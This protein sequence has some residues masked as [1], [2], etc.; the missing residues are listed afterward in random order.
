MRFLFCFCLNFW[1]AFLSLAQSQPS[2]DVVAP[3]QKDKN[4]PSFTI[5]LLDSTTILSTK[6]I[7]KEKPTV[8]V[9]FSPDCD[10][11]A[12]LARELKADSQQ[13]DEVNL[14]M[15]SPPMPLFDIKMFAHINGLVN[16]KL[17]VVGQDVDFF[18]GSFFRAETVPFVVIYDAKQKWFS[19]LK[20][21]RNLD[22]LRLELDKLKMD[23]K[24]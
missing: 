3:Y 20:N 21:M 22:E 9:L 13:F 8:F 16:K 19:T 18:F 2:E 15:L 17:I 7:A 5:R 4:L 10:H 12:Q 23:K 6:I 1:V 11:C 24:P 14:L